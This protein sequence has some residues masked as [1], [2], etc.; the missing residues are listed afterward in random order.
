MQ[1]SC[2]ICPYFFC[3]YVERPLWVEPLV[4]Q[5]HFRLCYLYFKQNLFM[6]RKYSLGS[7]SFLYV[8]CTIFHSQAI[9]N[10]SLTYQS[11]GITWSYMRHSLK[12]HT[13]IKSTPS[14]SFN[15]NVD[16]CRLIYTVPFFFE[17]KYI[18]YCLLILLKKIRRKATSCKK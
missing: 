12:L 1:V 5:F 3:T 4:K 6:S 18:Q 9:W 17:Q 15:A 2:F 11:V 10:N 8:C 14:D 16:A 7:D 13:K